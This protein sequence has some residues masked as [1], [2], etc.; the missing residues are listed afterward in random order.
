MATHSSVLAWR[1]PWT[2]G[3]GG[4]QSMESQRV[5]HDWATEHAHTFVFMCVSSN[6]DKASQFLLGQIKSLNVWVDKV[7]RYSESCQS[8]Q[9]STG[10][11][12]FKHWAFFGELSSYN[13]IW[14]WLEYRIHLFHYCYDVLSILD[15]IYS[16]FLKNKE[17]IML[18]LL[19]PYLIEPRRC[20]FSLFLSC[21][22]QYLS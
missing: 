17:L 1:I 2:E 7:V 10:N 9:F 14:L 8:I 4:L 21:I 5:G 22:V 19:S 6:L 13:N 3:P 18:H 20:L 15:L 12:L 16:S 11:L